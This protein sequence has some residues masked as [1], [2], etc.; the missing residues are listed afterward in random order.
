MVISARHPATAHP[1]AQRA[2]PRY[3]AN[4]PCRRTSHQR[5]ELITAAGW[6][7][8]LVAIAVLSGW[9]HHS[10]STAR[11]AATPPPSAAAT[12][13]P[14]TAATRPP[15]TAATPMTSG[16]TDT[17]LRAWLAQAEP[18]IDALVGARDDIA[19]AAADNDMP[20][21]GAACRTADDAIASLQQHMPTPDPELNNPL[22]Q[23]IS[24]FQVGLRYCISGA[25]NQQ[26][27]EIEQAATYIDRGNADLQT[28]VDI[29]ERD[30][31]GSAPRDP[32]V[33]T[34]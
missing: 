31:S 17:Q 11:P 28:A 13:P 25:Q 27:N 10:L 15:N 20:G 23:A 12:P 6:A 24:S 8:L 26:T 33:L 19:A 18:S 34:V 29:L 1:A 2:R 3:G 16:P 14:S 32:G 21:T 5:G 22:Q 9:A 30:L 7:V 4:P